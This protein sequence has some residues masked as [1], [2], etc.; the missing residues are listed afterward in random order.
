VRKEVVGNG[1]SGRHQGLT[2]HQSP[3]Y[4]REVAFEPRPY[5]DISAGGLEVERCSQG[6]GR[7]MGIHG[8]AAFAYDFV[9]TRKLLWNVI[10]VSSFWLTAR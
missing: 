1:A 4:P 8:K 5:E 7:R 9:A 2:E 6:N 10:T 3:E